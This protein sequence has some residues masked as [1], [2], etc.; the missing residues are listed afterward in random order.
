LQ[1]TLLTDCC[2]AIDWALPLQGLDHR[3]ATRFTPQR[4]PVSL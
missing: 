4:W 3:L 1:C 2:G